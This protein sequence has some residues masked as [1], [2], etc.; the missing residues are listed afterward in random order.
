MLFVAPYMLVFVGA[1]LWQ[2][3][4]GESAELRRVALDHASKHDE[5]SGTKN[6]HRE[7]QQLLFCKK[8]GK[9]FFFG[10]ISTQHIQRKRM[11]WYAQI[12]GMYLLFMS[13]TS[14]TIGI[15]ALYAKWATL[16]S[17]PSVSPTDLQQAYIIY[18]SPYYSCQ[19]TPLA[20]CWM[21]LN[22]NCIL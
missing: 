6:D 12:F 11:Q 5:D 20:L 4:T 14:D 8:G 19:Q 21:R 22:E 16:S 1:I 3:E 18:S 9:T 15:N 13:P 2:V 10:R 7:L 17:K